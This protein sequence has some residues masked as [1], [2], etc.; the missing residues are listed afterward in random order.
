MEDRTRDGS[1][2]QGGSGGDGG[3]RVM[4]RSSFVEV[5]AGP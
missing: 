2:S 3:V 5:W 4:S 1:R